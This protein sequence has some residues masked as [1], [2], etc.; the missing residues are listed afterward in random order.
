MEPQLPAPAETLID[1]ET[2]AGDL[3]L[4]DV[5]D[6]VLPHFFSEQ[7][8]RK[9]AAQAEAEARAAQ[10]ARGAA[11]W[12]KCQRKEQLSHAEFADMC[13]H[14]DPAGRAERSRKRYR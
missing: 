13:R 4:A 12:E 2:L 7:R 10:D 8:P 14:I 3:L 5:A 9:T 6:G 11:A 1:P